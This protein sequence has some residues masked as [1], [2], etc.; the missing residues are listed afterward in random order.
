MGY[1]TIAIIQIGILVL[2]LASLPLWK[3]NKPAENT[4]QRKSIKFKELLKITGV[5]QVLFIF[6]SYC[7]IEVTTGLWG[8][9]FLVRTR[10]VA[11]EIAAQWIAFY[12]I[13]IT[14]GRFL[15]GFVTLKL[16]NKQMIRLGQAIIGCG[17]VVLLLPL[18]N[19]ALL[20]GLFMIGLG[21]API[22]PC[23]VHKTSENFGGEHSQAIV[24]VQMASA[25]IGSTTMP[26]LFG[27][28]AST[29]GF[30]VFPIFIGIVL[31]IKILLTENLNR[32]V[33]NKI[34]S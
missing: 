22:F 33:E 13:G 20:P 7:T 32:K 24:G 6:F 10:N 34:L 27:L 28:L 19:N 4:S 15:S 30:Y 26:P 9:S 29:I 1:R 14:V 12:Y 25:Y 2:L 31:I 16:N 11:P 18:G 3:G 8:A 21:C 17:I 5:K 23:L